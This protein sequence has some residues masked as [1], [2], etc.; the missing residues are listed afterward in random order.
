MSVY[1]PFTPNNYSVVPFNAHKQ[2][3]FDFNSATVNKITFFK[4]KYNSNSI[5][6]YLTGSDL[7][8]EDN[9]KYNQLNH[10]FY[11]KY[12][13]N[14]NDKFGDINYLKHKRVLYD[15]VNIISIPSGLYGHK[16]KV[17]SLETKING[18]TYID[19][20][21]GNIINKNTNINDFV[22][23]PRSIL[24]DIGPNNGFKKYNLNTNY[25]TKVNSLSSYSTDSTYYEYDDSYFLN[26]IYYN[27]VN[28]SELNLTNQLN[29]IHNFPSI[30]FDTGSEIKVTH[31]DN[32]NFNENNNYSIEFWIDAKNDTSPEGEE[33]LIHVLS[34][35]TIQN[36]ITGPSEY[37]GAPGETQEINAG[38]QYPFKIYLQKIV[39]MT[40]LHFEV[41]DGDNTNR[42]SITLTRSTNSALPYH[43]TCVREGSTLKIYKDSINTQEALCTSK[44]TNNKANIYIGG[45][46]NIT[47][48][49][50]NNSF[51]GSLSNIK[52][53]DTA[54]TST[55]ISN[56]FDSKNASPYVGNIFYSHG[57]ITITHPSHQSN[58]GF[59]GIGN[60]Q[61][62]NSD[63]VPNNFTVG[64]IANTNNTWLSDIKFQ[65]SHLIYENEYK[66]TIDE[67]EYN[68]TLNPTARKLRSSEDENMA[69]FTTGSLFKPYITT[70]GL[71]NENN[72]LLVVGK[73]GQPI[74]TSNET[75]TTFV[76]RWDT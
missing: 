34:K 15:S 35:S 73:L 61:V 30:T 64:G 59:Y 62:D 42:C 66:C 36:T 22:T 40:L 18:Q 68:N 27:K 70:I 25:E 49:Y 9:V 7:S 57:L 55:Q 23:D 41:S 45:Q 60:M 72:E 48:K 46:S 24:L 63:T 28:F 53:Y 16:I 6:T 74:R 75:D 14:P 13:I 2:Y 76:V 50:N 20:S 38:N 47:S 39:D 11:K 43:I 1:K 19:D 33:T 3:N 56:H 26:H 4:A 67:F 51:S 69:D 65:G 44:I 71:Y 29:Q 17:N 58:F 31:N 52:I 12:K 37:D 5:D 10:L 32:L 8:E 21:Y 54:L